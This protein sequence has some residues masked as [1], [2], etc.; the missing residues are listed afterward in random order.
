MS[1]QLD[2]A[3][4]VDLVYLP[5]VPGQDDPAENY[6]EASKVHAES[7]RWDLPGA[8]RLARSP[9]LRTMAG[10]SAR[11]YDSRP[12]VPLPK[13]APCDAPLGELLASRRSATAFGG[14][15]VPLDVL[16]GVLDRSYGL[17]TPRGTTWLRPAPSA[18]ALHPLDLFVVNR[19]VV[20]L[21]TGGLYHFD[22]FRRLLADVGDCHHAAL[23]EALQAPAVTADPSF[24]VVVSAMFWRSRFKYGQRSL[25]FVLMEAGHVVQNLTLV[26]LAH[27]LHSRPLGGFQDDLLTALLP[28]HNGVDDAAVYAVPIG[29]PAG[30]DHPDS[31]GVPGHDLPAPGPYALP[32]DRETENWR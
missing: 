23:E 18:G 13:A 19:T 12:V 31:A 9:E 2:S 28:D 7:V 29:T 6:F 16:A 27:G 14:G 5:G 26:A 30:A 10:R 22:P 25:R 17:V 20:G 24:V 21:R 15:P 11:R 3:N 32:R 4:L 8:A 1:E